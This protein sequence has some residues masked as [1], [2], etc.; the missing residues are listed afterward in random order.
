MRPIRSLLFVLTAFA[1]GAFVTSCRKE[2]TATMRAGAGGKKY[3]GRYTLNEIRGNPSSLDPVR[4]NS[5]VEDDIA[6]NI[7]DHLVD[8][9]SSLHVE[10]ELAKSWEI[11]E[12]GK[13]YVFH[14]RTDAYFHDDKCFPNGKGRKFVAADAKYSLER[15]CD[16]KTLTSGFWIFQGIVIGADD[17][18]YRDSLNKVGKNITGVSG[19]EAANDSTFIVHLIKPFAPFLEHLT[20]SFGFVTAHEAVETYGKDFFQHPV[21]T[22]AFLFVDWKPDEEILLKRNPHYWQHDSSG[23]QLP[24]LDE[25]RFTMIKDDKTLLANFDRATQDEDFTLPTESFQNVVTAEKTLTPEYQKKNYQLQHITAMNSYFIDILCT[26]PQYSNTALR[27]AMSFG[28][29]RERI[30]KYVLKNM[31]HSAANNFIVPPAFADYPIG[32]VHGIAFNPDSAR[33]WL[34]KA[35]FGASNPLVIKLAVYNE[36]SQMQIAQAVQDMWKV[37]LGASVELNVMQSGQLLDQSEDGKLDV[38]VTRWYADYPEIENFLNLLYGSLVPT[39]E[40]MKSYPNSTR[41]NNKEFNN[42][43]S[44]ALETTD[45]A[46]RVKLYAEAENIAASEAPCIPL[47]YQEHYRLL[48]PW[49]RNNPLDAMNRIDLK[50]VWLDK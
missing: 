48:Q 45:D 19:F 10:A 9:N 8:N 37:N 24:L 1:I 36:P 40:A 12:D 15:V 3:G 4:M 35:G 44:R 49:V 21:G 22:G 5:K 28:V 42:I 26:S 30:V 13:T 29:D 20:T 6:T 38:W 25:V 41:W 46:A 11:S 18:F 39:N 27:R 34:G 32:D 2:N 50:W 17:Y 14:L 33:Y 47:F 7:Y 31:P 16:P 43:F 23:N